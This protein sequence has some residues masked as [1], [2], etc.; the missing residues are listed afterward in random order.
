P[1]DKLFVRLQSNLDTS[2][3]TVS[4]APRSIHD[5]NGVVSADTIA[6]IAVRGILTADTTGLRIAFVTPPDS[7]RSVR[8]G[9]SIV[10]RFSDAVDTANARLTIMHD[11]PQGAV[12]VIAAWIDPT[13]LQ[14][15]PAQPRSTKSWYQTVVAF[16][17]VRS[18]LGA[19]LRDTILRHSLFTEERQTEPG[20]VNGVVIDTFGLAPSQ[21][22]LHLRFIN[23]ARF[24]ALT[25]PIVSGVPFEVSSIP[26]GLYTID[27]FSDLNGNGIY[28][29][30][31]HTPF[32][33][34][35]PWWPSAS[36]V[37]IRSRWTVEGVRF[38]FGSA[39]TR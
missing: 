10:I 27:V 31:D 1:G 35:E 17:D 39:S 8:T 21:G 23:S 15:R 28:D 7:A 12:P 38:Y 22:K 16:S 5:S 9:E 2:R 19:R 14:L 3:Y 11:S 13:T 36:A 33:R 32:T 4:L 6:R 37:E 26:V 25:I 29:H 34:G 18:Y 20:S 30:G 24:V